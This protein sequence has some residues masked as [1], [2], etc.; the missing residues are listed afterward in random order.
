MDR[1]ALW[2][3]LAAKQSRL[4]LKTGVH[5]FRHTLLTAVDQNGGSALARDI[6]GHTSVHVT[7]RYM[8]SSMEERLDVL[9][10]T[11]LARSLAVSSK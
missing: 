11:E 10:S 8:H 5:I 9:N 1:K 2:S 3:A 7:N 4:E 6:G